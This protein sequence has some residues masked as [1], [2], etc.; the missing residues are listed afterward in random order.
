[1][2]CLYTHKRAAQENILN[3]T[4]NDANNMRKTNSTYVIR[5]VLTRAR[6]PIRVDRGGVSP[7]RPWRVFRDFFPYKSYIIYFLFLLGLLHSLFGQ[8]QRRRQSEFERIVFIKLVLIT[9][10]YVCR[11]YELLIPLPALQL[12][13]PFECFLEFMR[14]SS[15]VAIDRIVAIRRQF[16]THLVLYSDYHVQVKTAVETHRFSL[17]NVTQRPAMS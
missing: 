3:R 13:H 8:Q 12:K 15:V 16:L 2:K 4:R 9:C 17:T 11:T 1:M 6:A 7:S 5:A 14:V 10:K